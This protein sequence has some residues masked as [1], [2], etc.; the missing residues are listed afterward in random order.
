M[1]SLSKPVLATAGSPKYKNDGDILY[2]IRIPYSVCK[3]WHDVAGT[4]S[5]KYSSLLH[6]YLIENH[7]LNL[8]QDTHPR[9]GERLRRECPRISKKF[10]NI[11]GN[12]RRNLLNK[13][14]TL[15]IRRE[16]LLTFPEVDAVHGALDDALK[17][18][19][20]LE[21]KIST[22]EEQIHQLYDELN[23][24]K[25]ASD[26]Q[27][28]QL[29]NEINKS[30]NLLETNEGLQTYVEHLCG[31]SVGVADKSLTKPFSSCSRSY[32]LRR[33]KECKSRAGCALWFIDT[34]GLKLDSLTLKDDKGD[35]HGIHFSSISQSDKSTLEKILYLLDRFYVSDAFYH[36]LSVICDGL[37]KSYLIKQL[38]GRMNTICHVEQTPGQA[39]GAQIDAKK[40][41]KFAI[42]SFLER[43]PEVKNL[44]EKP[45][46]SVKFCGDGTAG[47]RKNCMCVMS[48]ALFCSG[49]SVSEN[50]SSSHYAVAVVKGQE[51]YQLYRDSFSGV[52]DAINDLHSQ[53]LLL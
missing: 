34:Y 29:E 41:V 36:E 47:S 4:S 9:L 25:L 17:A 40:E 39:E 26:A 42:T 19:S 48:F 3:D 51:S 52:W 13:V 45:S 1:P 6:E 14:F 21:E 18:V 23:D 12:Q 7:C 33:L 15:N 46:F 44:D 16:E 22:L 38:R 10:K 43:N 28:K 5:E 2:C 30:N 11:G 27:S 35:S 53:G 24:C 50:T 49:N 32:Q 20:S 31:I 8:K 37:P